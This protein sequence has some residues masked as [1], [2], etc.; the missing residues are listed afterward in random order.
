MAIEE[1]EDAEKELTD[2]PDPEER[3]EEPK[4]DPLP[5]E[6]TSL[7]EEKIIAFENPGEPRIVSPSLN[8]RDAVAVLQ[9]SFTFPGPRRSILSML[10]FGSPSEGFAPANGSPTPSSTSSRTVALPSYSLKR[11]F[12]FGSVMAVLTMSGSV[13]IRVCVPE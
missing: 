5:V 9:F 3:S 13:A 8:P 11:S 6:L 10:A 12:V 2:E 4:E 7:D 1:T